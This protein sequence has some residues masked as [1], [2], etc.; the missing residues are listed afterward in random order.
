MSLDVDLVLEHHAGG[1]AVV[2]PGRAEGRHLAAAVERF[3][4]ED[5]ADAVGRAVR[6]ARVL[7]TLR[8]IDLRVLLESPDVV[9]GVRSVGTPGGGMDRGSGL[10]PAVTVP[11]GRPAEVL[12]VILTQDLLDAVIA[13][14]GQRRFTG[15]VRMDLGP[16][17]R[18][19]SALRRLASAVDARP[20]LV[21]DV[22]RSAVTVLDLAGTSVVGA[23]A[24][25]A[26][27]LRAALGCTL[28]PSLRRATDAAGPL[29]PWIHLSAPPTVVAAVREV[30]AALLP[31]G[32]SIDVA[33]LGRVG[34]DR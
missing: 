19:R 5:L 10:A 30:T 3:H 2:V 23:R 16:L 32:G 11:A 34:R 12:D 31:P 7:R 22:T 9:L 20:G 25:R 4:G 17:V 18:A 24:V 21:V 8:S 15:T 1:A 27:D 13:G 26:I 6:G 14:L 29:R 28:A 33:V